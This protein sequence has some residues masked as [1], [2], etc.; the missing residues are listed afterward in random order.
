MPIVL[1][2]SRLKPGVA[3]DEYEDFVRSVDYPATKRI[4]SISRYQSV[5]LQGPAV[6]EEELP[7]DFIDLAEITDI[8]KYREDLEHHPAVQ[9]VHGQFE[10]YVASIGNLW[11][12]QVGEG[13]IRKSD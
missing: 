7:Y 4:A 8:G 11:A 1:W 10:S 6:G 13:A 3:A 9:E 12:V 5:R 2:F